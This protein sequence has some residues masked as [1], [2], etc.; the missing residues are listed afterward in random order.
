MAQAADPVSCQVLLPAAHRRAAHAQLAR[1][2]HL[3]EPASA[4]QATGS[5]PA[6][7]P[8]RGRQ[9]LRLPHHEVPSHVLDLPS[10]YLLY[11]TPINYR[12]RPERRDGAHLPRIP[13]LEPSGDSHVL[14]VL[15]K[16]DHPA[17]QLDC[18]L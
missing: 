14:E 13:A 11:L 1:N 9:S 3:G 7:L 6:L 5:Q 12:P 18:R 2:L 10:C 8:L 17:G 4:E 15:V 16:Y